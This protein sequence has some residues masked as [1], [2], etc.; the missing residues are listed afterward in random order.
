MKEITFNKP[1]AELEKIVRETLGE[2]KLQSMM[3]FNKV[4]FN[5]LYDQYQTELVEHFKAEIED[6]EKKNSQNRE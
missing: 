3:G 2:E 1:S 5:D 6:E 4:S